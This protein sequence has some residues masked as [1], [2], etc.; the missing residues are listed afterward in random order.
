MSRKLCQSI[1]GTA[2][3][4]L[5]VLLPAAA[6]AQDGATISGRV[7]TQAGLPLQAASVFIEE[8]NIGTLTREDGRY[9]FLVPAARVQGQTVTLTAR[10]VG[11]RAQSV[12]ITLQAGLIE[13]DFTLED[14]P[15]RLGEVVVTGAGTVSPVERLGTVRNTV[16]QE[17]VERAAEPNIVQ[18]LAGKAPNVEITQQSGEAGASSYIRIRGLNTI[19]GS[20]QPLFVVDG[21]PID[22]STLATG[23]FLASTVA[24][25]RAMDIN[26]HD[27]ENIEILKG[28]A[29]AAI[30]GA[31]AAQGVVLITTRRGRPGVTRYSL[32]SQFSVDEVNQRV[33]LQ[34]RWGIGYLGFSPDDFGATPMDLPF[35][36]GP[37]LDPGTPRFDH[38]D[39]VFRRGNTFDNTLTL[40]G[41]SERTTFYLSAGRL[42]QTGIIVGPNNWF[43]RNS[44]RL[45]ASHQFRDDLNIGA[46]ISYVD[47]RGAFIQKGSNLSGLLLG[48]LRTPPEF[49]NRQYLTEDGLHRSYRLPNPTGAYTSRGYDN[50]FWIAN[51]HRNNSTV[52]R[53]YGN[54]NVEWN[55]LEW[56]GVKYTLGADYSN[57]ERLE[58]L[59]PSS[60]DFPS[61]L[62]NRADFVN[63]QIDHN[64]LLTGE[65]S[66]ADNLIGRL[67]LGHNLNSQRFT[68]NFTTGFTWIAP[69]GPFSLNNTIDLVPNEFRS[70]VHTESYFGQAELDIGDQLYLTAS[71]RNDGFSTFG[72]SERRHWFPK[73]SA[74]YTFTDADNIPGVTEG[75]LRAAW[76]MAGRAP[77]VYQT[78]TAFSLANVGDGGWG[79]FLRPAQGGV[80]GVT[81]G[82]L[83]GQPNLR[84]ERTAELEA[85]FDLGLFNGVA[86]FSATYY[87]AQSRDVI[88]LT[89]LATTTG[90]AVQ[91]R[92][93]ARIS[94]R[95][96]ELSLNVRPI[97]EANTSWDLGFNW[98]SNRNRVRA[99][100]GVNFVDMPGAFA[101][102]PG[103]AWA[104]FPVGV[105][106]GFDFARCRYGEESNVVGGVDINAA[107]QAAGA[108]NGALY[109]D[110]TGFPITDPTTRVIMDPNPDWTGSIRTSLRF[111]RSVQISA[112]MDIRRGGQVWNGTRGALI[113]FGTHTDTE[114][115]YQD[116]TFGENYFRG[117]VVGPGAGM[118]VTLD[119]DWFLG[120]GG[121][122]GDVASHFI[123]DGS[124]VKLR[125]ISLGYTMDNAFVRSTLG[126]SSLDLRI[127]GRNLAT[128]TNYTGIDPETNLGGAEVAL[129]GIDYF[130][131]PQTRSFVFT[132]GLNR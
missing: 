96:V 11:Y 119:E 107:C 40:S 130:N 31:R 84:P 116:V 42:D 39:A 102:A 12:P 5:A 78:I 121:G 120:N 14:T 55:P 17:L 114:I 38:W 73:F 126:L 64:L 32:R 80:G 109:L 50:P 82:L 127:A 66:L 41:G 92:N 29:A 8:L 75:K 15:L 2:A 58:A 123:E 36:W 44:A 54:V 68:Q 106:R 45:N 56:L 108:P 97:N 81:S 105:L 62:I 125:E 30:Y 86:D 19:Q 76:G 48:A 26:P 25:N 91:A 79:P 110:G 131:N 89:P 83:L 128:W 61:G 37:E 60:S 21:T 13:R 72:E 49:D 23:S 35:A 52:G 69:Q 115:R 20:G 43:E 122:F 132:I 3:V 57:D 112:L 88:F 16:S 59:P 117:P 1:A 98:A 27:I 65:Q 22:N 18:A 34:Q 67:T 104:G 4:A 28:A 111:M 71:L 93:A 6:Q 70:L 46:N 10:L 63:Y 103:T 100:E 113:Y 124:F 129:R 99:M 51:A 24:P 74:A 53:A 47:S 87:D 9:T 77:G 101:G 85:G 7:A 33:P 90:F 95:G 94:N 118:Q